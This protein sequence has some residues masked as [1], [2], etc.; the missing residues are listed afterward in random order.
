MAVAIAYLAAT[1]TLESVI[2]SLIGIE[3]VIEADRQFL[4]QSLVSATG[5]FGV[6][7]VIKGM[8]GAFN[9]SSFLG[10]AVGK[11]ISPV[12]ETVHF[13][14]KIF[15]LSMISVV[16]QIG[17]LHFFQIVAI[18]ICVAAGMII[19]VLSLGY[20]DVFKK[21]SLALVCIGMV[22]YC[23]MPYSIYFSK[24][25]FENSALEADRHLEESLMQFK[26]RVKE[27]EVV[28]IKNL[29]PSHARQTVAR[30][31]TS[32]SA[33][34]DVLINA[35]VRYFTL[36]IIMFVISPLFFYGLAY[37]MIKKALDCIGVPHITVKL[38]NKIIKTVRGM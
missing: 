17:L 22:L 33:G 29:I 21:V 5:H 38:D 32:M 23:L 10:I 20:V 3:Q 8:L 35:L 11:I 34:L 19:Y 37:L 13:I 9:D 26:Q 7:S 2:G 31:Q 1:G 25:M 16:A 36:L 27:I 15:G 6:L 24:V 4:K 28:S 18:R 30:I 14:W 12:A